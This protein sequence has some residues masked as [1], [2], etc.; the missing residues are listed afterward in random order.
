MST[1]NR[2]VTSAS[3]LLAIP[4]IVGGT[5]LIGH[6]ASAPKTRHVRMVSVSQFRTN[7][8]TGTFAGWTMVHSE[9]GARARIQKRLVRSGHWAAE[10]SASAIYGSYAYARRI[11]PQAEQ[12]LTTS[13]DFRIMAEGLMHSNVP[14]L[15]LFN[16]ANQRVISIYRQN[17]LRNQI[18]VDYHGIYR[19]TTGVLP[20]NRWG[21]LDVQVSMGGK[22]A[23]SVEVRLNGALIYRDMHARLTGTSLQA[24]QIGDEARHQRFDV[25][26]DN[27]AVSA[28]VVKR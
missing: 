13:A 25:A 20:L 24:I 5:P 4:L 26:V 17:H 19:R 14:L 10:F 3:L 27:V 7:F 12:N 28:V 11:L 22:S 18:W 16:A 2:V 21:H 23:G 6:T 1:S 15:R 9:S 8:E